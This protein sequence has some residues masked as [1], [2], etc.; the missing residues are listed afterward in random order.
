MNHRFM[1]IEGEANTLVPINLTIKLKFL[2]KTPREICL[3]APPPIF[4]L[5]ITVIQ[6]CFFLYYFIKSDFD[7][8]KMQ[9][10]HKDSFL[11]FNPEKRQELLRFFTYIFLHQGYIFNN[12]IY[13]G[14]REYQHLI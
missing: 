10:L 9:M 3:T 7:R 5:T 12:I 6:I 4:F 8:N 2:E 1:R 13:T 14:I 11:I